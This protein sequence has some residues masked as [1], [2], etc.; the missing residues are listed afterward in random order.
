MVLPACL[1]EQHH[2]R[3]SGGKPYGFAG[4]IRKLSIL[5]NSQMFL[6]I[7]YKGLYTAF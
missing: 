6:D 2:T 3:V 4:V 7:G 1:A 5:L